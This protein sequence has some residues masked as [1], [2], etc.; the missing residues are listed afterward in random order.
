MVR[1]SSL[2]GK[3]F[4]R[5]KT[6]NEPVS[7]VRRTTPAGGGKTAGGNGKGPRGQVKDAVASRLESPPPPPPKMEVRPIKKEDAQK[8]V[9]QGLQDLSD[10]LKGIQGR[11]ESQGEK[12]GKLLET[13]KDLPEAAQAQIQ[14]LKKISKQIGDFLVWLKKKILQWFCLM[15]AQMEKFCFQIWRS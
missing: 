11:M 7:P 15:P 8:A 4:T 14:F 13:F 12:T 10:L 3:L 2:L 5:K 6:L 9:V 1:K